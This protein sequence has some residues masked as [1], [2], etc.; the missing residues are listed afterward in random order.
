MCKEKISIEIRAAEGGEDAKLLVKDMFDIYQKTSRLN[1]FSI[2]N[3]ER[4]EGII[5]FCL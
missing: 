3:V 4:K 5:S 1:N 2:S